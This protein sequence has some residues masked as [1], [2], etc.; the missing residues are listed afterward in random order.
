MADILHVQRR[1][2]RGT[3]N[4]KQLRA[5]GQVPAVLYGH[6]GETISI[7]ARTDELA[8]AL[9]HGARLV[10]LTG[11]V[12]QSALIRETQ[13]DAFGLQ[14]L[15]VD[16]TRVRVGESVETAVRVQLR[17]EAPGVRHGGMVEHH[18]H[19]LQIECPVT[20]IPEKLSLNINELEL[21][22]S[23]VAEAVTLPDGAKLLT[24]PSAVVV[25]CSVPVAPE[26]E[27]EG[28]EPVEPEVIGRKAAGEESESE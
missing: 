21:G 17:G 26:E 19:V 13:W 18:L 27:A 9:R 14:L 10:E 15:H 6:G 23:I 1:E 7:A 16:F 24:E 8:A 12:Q 3:R 2:T 22:Q 28:A 11:D 4:A 20:A 5:A 25:H